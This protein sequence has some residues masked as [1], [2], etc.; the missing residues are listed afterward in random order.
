[1]SCAHVRPPP[2]VPSVP[3]SAAPQVDI[4]KTEWPL[5][6]AIL[7]DCQMQFA[8]LNIELHG[9]NCLQHARFFE[10]IDKCGYVITY[11]ETNHW[12]GFGYQFVEYTIIS[13]SH[14][15]REFGLTHQCEPTT[16][17]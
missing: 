15:R 16:V 7:S 14:A 5:F 11:K 3:G 6:A 12:G 4:E 8:H 17:G 2:P 13:Q 9:T 1:M 10:A